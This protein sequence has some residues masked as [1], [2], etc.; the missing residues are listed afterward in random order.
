MVT[1][2]RK[3]NE[4]GWSRLL[5]RNWFTSVSFG[6]RWQELYLSCRLFAS[7][8]SRRMSKSSSACIALDNFFYNFMNRLIP[9]LQSVIIPKRGRRTKHFEKSLIALGNIGR[10]LPS[11]QR[12]IR[13]K[14]IITVNLRHKNDKHVN[15]S[16]SRT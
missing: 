10:N 16:S 13:V 15:Y 12:Q 6:G 14:L 3:R 4:L 8:G 2:K 7:L 5:R 1:C 11:F 9:F